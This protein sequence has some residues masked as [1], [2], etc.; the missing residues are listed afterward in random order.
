MSKSR[1]CSNTLGTTD[2][3]A[4]IASQLQ[5]LKTKQLEERLGSVE[6]SCESQAGNISTASQTHLQHQGQEQCEGS[7]IISTCVVG[8]GSAP[9]CTFQHNYR[10]PLKGGYAKGKTKTK[11]D[12]HSLGGSSHGHTSC[13][14]V[15]L[16]VPV[17]DGHLTQQRAR[18]P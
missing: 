4:L 17:G 8:R 13:T 14:S 18:A 3:S 5:E 6:T 1:S 11:H 7:S 9:F 10:R 16:C 12:G 15:A 2:L